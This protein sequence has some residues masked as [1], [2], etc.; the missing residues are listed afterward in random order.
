MGV[1]LAGAEARVVHKVDGA[2]V[3]VFL[4]VFAL[5]EKEWREGGKGMESE[6][7]WSDGSIDTGR[8][9]I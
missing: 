5:M 9:Y 4:E 1:A 6:R 7:R 8:K 3:R 2:K